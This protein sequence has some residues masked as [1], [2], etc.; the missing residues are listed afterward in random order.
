MKFSENIKE[1]TDVHIT[2]YVGDNA[3]QFEILAWRNTGVR[4]GMES[5]THL[6]SVVISVLTVF[7]VA[8]FPQDTLSKIKVK[9]G[10]K[11]KK[12]QTVSIVKISPFTV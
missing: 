9:S 12:F 7:L 1:D 8:I 10:S 2:L 6:L 3:A 11:N 5:W 4:V